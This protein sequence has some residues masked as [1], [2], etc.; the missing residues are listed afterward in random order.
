MRLLTMASPVWL[1][2][3]STLRKYEFCLSCI[4]PFSKEDGH[5]HSKMDQK[6]IL[7]AEDLADSKIIHPEK[8]NEELLK[9]L[10]KDDRAKSIYFS[11]DFPDDI[12]F[13]DERLK[14]IEQLT[15]KFRAVQKHIGFGN[16]NLIGMDEFFHYASIA[17][18]C[19]AVL[20]TEKIF[21]E[22]LFYFDGA[23]Y[24][25]KGEKVAKNFTEQIKSNEVYK[26]PYTGHFLRKDNSL[27]LYEKIRND[28]GEDLLLTSGVRGVAKQFHLFFEKGLSTKGNMSKA[29]RS[30]APPGYSFH[31]QGDFDVGRRGFGLKN[32]T[33][34]FAETDEFKRLLDLGYV[35]IRYT[36]NNDLGV[37]FEPW[38]IKV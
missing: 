20:A 14:A 7:G 23:K 5:S 12:F 9:D 13:E 35:N 24:G 16:F 1:A 30:L 10:I 2:G 31:F 17:P 27:P 33:D 25:F 8:S 34:S 28:I 22:E 32:F 29:S 6:E 26:V 36:L 18:K 11:Q 19:E 15:R 38:H 21:L 3:C 37:R 4:N